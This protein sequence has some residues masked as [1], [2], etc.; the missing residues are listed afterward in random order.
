MKKAISAA[1]SAALLASLLATA[2]APGALAATPVGSVGSVPRGGTSTNAATFT[3]S[4]ETAGCISGVLG[5][6]ATFSVQI[7]Q[8]GGGGAGN[9]TFTG[10][11]VVTAPGI[12][13]ATVSLTAPIA[14][15]MLVKI[16]GSD[17]INK[18]QISITGLKIKAKAGAALGAITATLNDVTGTVAHCFL[19]STGNPTGTVAV[20]V[21]SGATSVQVT[22]P[23][24]ASCP[25]PNAA[26]TVSFGGANAESGVAVTAA[27]AY[28]GTQTLTIGGTGT[29]QSHLVGD[30][31]TSSATC[32]AGT[33]PFV[34]A[35]KASA[36]LFLRDI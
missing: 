5:A 22:V 27:T 36:V 32:P 30:S 3:F 15:T 23:N 13:G 31:V 4:E 7:V 9:V 24:G 6:S 25:F 14:D 29:G 33:I 8:N 17:P 18:Q 28:T 10:T 21:G 2:V 12:L 11:P 16:T 35:S 19:G 34:L 26:Q 20:A 1:T